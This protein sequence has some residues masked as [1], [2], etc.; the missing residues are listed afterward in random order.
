[1]ISKSIKKP[2]RTEHVYGH[3]G[4]AEGRVKWTLNGYLHREDGPAIE[5]ANGDKEW[6]IS[7][8]HHREDGPAIEYVNGTKYWYINGLLHREDG[9]AV[10]YVDGTKSWYIKGLLLTEEEFNIQIKPKPIRTELEGRVE[11]RLDGKLHREDGPALE[12]ASGNKY[13]YKNGEFHR[14]DGPAIEWAD[15]TKTWYLDGAMLLE[16]EFDSR[17]SRPDSGTIKEPIRKKL[18]NRVEWRLNG[19]LHREDGPAV[20]W[21]NGDQAWY[22]N[23]KLHRMNGPAYINGDKYWYIN[24]QELT[25]EEFNIKI[26]ANSTR[27]KT[28]DRVEWRLNEML[29]RDDGP[30][31]ETDSGDK[32]WYKNGMLHRKDGPAIEHADGSKWWYKNDKLHRRGGP[33]VEYKIDLGG[34]TLSRSIWYK[35]GQRHRKDGPAIES[36]DGTKA[37]YINDIEFSKEDFESFNVENKIMVKTTYDNRTEWKLHNLLHRENGPAVEYLNGTKEWRIKGKLHREDGPA[38]E[39]AESKWWYKNGAIHRD[40]APAVEFANGNKFWCKNG[41]YHRADGPAIEYAN[42]H[43]EW[44]FH[45]LLVTEQDLIQIDSVI[46]NVVNAAGRVIDSP[47]QDFNEVAALMAD[48]E[49]VAEDII[50]KSAE[51]IIG[52]SAEDIIGKSAEGND[53][54]EPDDSEECEPGEGWI[55]KHIAEAEPGGWIVP[56]VDD[57]SLTR[58]ERIKQVMTKS[59]EDIGK[60]IVRGVKLETIER[61]NDKVY[62]T[63]SQLLVDQLGV[64]KSKLDSPIMKEAILTMVPLFLH[65][66]AVAMDG[67]VA[68]AK[69]AKDYAETSIELSAKRNS[70]AMIDS[71]SA[72]FK[73]LYESNKSHIPRFTFSTDYS[74]LAKNKLRILAQEKSLRIQTSQTKQELVEALEQFELEEAGILEQNI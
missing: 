12:F 38:I 71:L 48:F 3:G 42:G 6:Y 74:K 50:G 27:T 53:R 2:I 18:N 60:S 29:H 67:K 65:P 62:E 33:A 34:K 39:S 31:I 21:T 56:L 8:N 41:K 17:S 9:P 73:L 14:E 4:S 26:K 70:G 1:M 40:D 64:D 51:D 44:Y 19:R 68:Y 36:S 52:K 45:G 32:Y 5:C 63:I 49:K 28:G 46:Q 10:E 30:A 23:G 59:A 24:G 16:A 7:G 35:N 58:T 47:V 69:W 11:Y 57:Y 22:R 43:T 61:A 66:V 54:E 72:M 20:E 15:G 13:W 25:K 55:A 37:W